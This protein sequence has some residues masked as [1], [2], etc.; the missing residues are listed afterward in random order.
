MQIHYEKKKEQFEKD[1]EN[2]KKDTLNATEKNEVHQKVIGEQAKVQ[3]AAI[4]HVAQTTAND[5]KI[6]EAAAQAVKV[7]QAKNAANW[8]KAEKPSINLGEE[9]TEESTNLQKQAYQIPAPMMRP[10]PVSN[11]NGFTQQR[12]TADSWDRYDD[13]ENR[14]F[15]ELDENTFDD[16][17]MTPIQNLQTKSYNIHPMNNDIIPRNQQNLQIYMADDFN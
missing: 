2:S 15:Q 14:E 17:A 16:P 6:M 5:K 4:W 3:E 8:E 1:K 13:E 11:R 10:L 7:D 12:S 9:Y